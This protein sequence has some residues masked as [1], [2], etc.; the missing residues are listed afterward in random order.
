MENKDFLV[1]NGNLIKY[2]GHD[3]V[4]RVPKEVT[5]E[6]HSD[7]FV[8]CP[9]IET[10]YI[11]ETTKSVRLFAFEDTLRK[12]KKIIV[13]E[14]N[15]YY[16]SIDGVLYNKDQTKLLICPASKC[17]DFVIPHTVKVVE[18]GAF[19]YCENLRSIH[20]SANVEEIWFDD[21][22]FHLFDGIFIV[23]PDNPNFE[24]DN[25]I[26]YTKNGCCSKDKKI[27]AIYC[28]PSKEGEVVLPETTFMTG[29]AAFKFCNKITSIVFKARNSLSLGDYTFDDCT[30]LKTLE[31]PCDIINFGDNY[32]RE[33]V[34]VT[35]RVDDYNLIQEPE[36]VKRVL[37]LTKK[38]LF[39]LPKFLAISDDFYELLVEENQRSIELYYKEGS[40]YINFEI[41]E[42]ENG[43]II[44]HYFISEDRPIFYADINEY[45]CYD[46]PKDADLIIPEHVIETVPVWDTY[47]PYNEYLFN[48]VSISKSLVDYHQG[49][50]TKKFIVNKDNPKYTAINGDLYSKDGKTL[51]ACAYKD[52]DEC[53]EI[54]EGVTAIEGDALMYVYG[55]VIIPKTVTKID[56]FH[57]EC[58]FVIMHVNKEFSMDYDGFDASAINFKEIYFEMNEEEAKESEFFSAYIET[59]EIDNHKEIKLFCIK[60]DQYVPLDY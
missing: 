50:Q 4:V 32:L 10:I 9:L 58:L 17:G 3:V 59:I 18:S 51:V 26:L 29:Y 24:F 12:L 35:L 44:G 15:P 52:K 37:P 48:S 5:E 30:S 31:M 33:T 60:D 57:D 41:E 22:D 16:S 56:W 28:K 38:V 23:D 2:L 13:D 49:L 14:N 19:L 47:F 36:E 54:P 46:G 6:V 34:A 21:Y 40:E 27:M 8:D 42:N 7:A 45:I 11:P 43:P 1:E 55:G 20:I 53:L 25:D 39:N